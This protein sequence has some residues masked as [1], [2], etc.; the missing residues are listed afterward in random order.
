M[1]NHRYAI[2]ALALVGS[3]VLISCGSDNNSNNNTPTDSGVVVGDT[4]LSGGSTAGL[5]TTL[6]SGSTG[7]STSGGDSTPPVGSL[8]TDTTN[9]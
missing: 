4:T 8:S 5:G 2:A 9:P 1:R 7:D 3:T 6:G